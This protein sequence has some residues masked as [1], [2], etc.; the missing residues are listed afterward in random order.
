MQSTSVL[1]IIPMQ[2]LLALGSDARMN[3]PGTSEWN[4]SCRF[5]WDQVRPELAGDLHAQVVLAERLVLPET[6]S[7]NTGI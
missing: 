5:S 4:W 2:D 7:Q 3:T 1:T 6:A